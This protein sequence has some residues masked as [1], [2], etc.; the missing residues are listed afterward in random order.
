MHASKIS[1]KRSNSGSTSTSGSSRKADHNSEN[2]DG[3]EQE[4]QK[5]EGRIRKQVTSHK[6]ID[7]RSLDPSPL[8]CLASLPS[9]A[10]FT[11]P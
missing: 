10:L 9:L 7:F 2:E 5:L 1:E 8:L 6:T 4:K 11:I 3:Q